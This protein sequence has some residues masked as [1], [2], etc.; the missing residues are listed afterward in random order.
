MAAT[1]RKRPARKY[2]KKE[3]VDISEEDRK[4]G[5]IYI[6]HM[7]HGFCEKE[8]QAYFSQ[9]GKVLNVKVSRSTKNGHAKG[10]AFVKFK[11]AAVAKTVAETCHN[12][13]FFN[14][15]L[16]CQYRPLEEVHPRTFVSYPWKPDMKRKRQ[17]NNGKS[18]GKLSTSLK[19]YTKKQEGK[20]KKLK[21]IG[22]DIKLSDILDVP[23]SR[24]SPSKT[25]QT[26]TPQKKENNSASKT[27]ETTKKIVKRKQTLSTKK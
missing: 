14:K 15:L 11:Y 20:L 16:K 19:V 6:G 1:T 21:E 3:K 5:V 24:E 27:K 17:H 12:Y 26:K 13:L 7:P 18:E 23:K 22:L 4:P 25:P 10:Y 2:A 8:L 9:F